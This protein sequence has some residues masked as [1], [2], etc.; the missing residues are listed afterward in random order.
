[1]EAPTGCSQPFPVSLIPVQLHQPQQHQHQHFFPLVSPFGP[2]P[3]LASLLLDFRSSLGRALGEV[4]GSADVPC[5]SERLAGN[6]T[7]LQ[8]LEQLLQAVNSD[9]VRTLERWVLDPSTAL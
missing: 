7:S 1:M 4:P 9:D 2:C 5:D 8:D 6:D 3:S